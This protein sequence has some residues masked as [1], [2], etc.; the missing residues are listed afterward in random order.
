[1]A[2]RLFSSITNYHLYNTALTIM[3][4]EGSHFG[5]LLL[6]AFNPCS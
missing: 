1:M 2:L 4:M 5:V 6:Q 3:E